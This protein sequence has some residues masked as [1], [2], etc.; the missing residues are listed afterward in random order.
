MRDPYSK[1]KVKSDKGKHLPK[2]VHTCMHAHVHT[3]TYKQAH[4]NT[5][6]HTSVPLTV[7]IQCNSYYVLSKGFQIT[8]E[9]FEGSWIWSHISQMWWALGCYLCVNTEFSPTASSKTRQHNWS[10]SKPGVMS[11]PRDA[12]K[13]FT[14]VGGLLCPWVY[15]PICAFHPLLPVCQEEME[16]L[17]TGTMV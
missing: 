9:Y 6:I 12:A 14:T 4:S 5:Y 15:S 10:S 13:L 16:V 7:T 8:E 1:T 3:H 2:H 17:S 11:H